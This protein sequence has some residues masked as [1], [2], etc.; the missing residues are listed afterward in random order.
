MTKPD[1]GTR[2]A[3][4]PG[5][6]LCATDESGLRPNVEVAGRQE[7]SSTELKVDSPVHFAT[8]KRS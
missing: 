2:A 3:N 1:R 8:T 7:P 6:R 5:E 4:S